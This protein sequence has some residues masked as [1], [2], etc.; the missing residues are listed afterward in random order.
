MQIHIRI[1]Y[2]ALLRERLHRSEE[3]L[4]LPHGSTVR[5]ALQILASREEVIGAIA[6]SLLLAVNQTLVPADFPFI[7]GD[8]F[9][10]LLFVVGGSDATT[11][12]IAL[13]R[14]RISRE[15]LQA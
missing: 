12:Q 14:C 10:L 8:E 13:P 11:A 4:A 15:P 9:A 1:L 7:D 6:K 5:D 2:F 3:S